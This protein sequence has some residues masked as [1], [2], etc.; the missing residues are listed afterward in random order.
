[1]KTAQ[2][3]TLLAQQTPPVD[4]QAFVR[5]LTWPLAIGGLLAVLVSVVVI[6]VLPAQ[7]FAQPVIWVKF[8]YGVALSLSLAMLLAR[9][10]RPGTPRADAVKWPLAVVLVL[11]G[12]GLVHLMITPPALWAS[13]IFS[14]T[15]FI[16]PWMVLLLSLPTLVGLLLAARALAPTDLRAAGFTAG[17]LAGAI[18]ALA[19]SLV[20]PELSLTFVALWYS[21]GIVLVGLVGWLCAPV[22]LRW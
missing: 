2:L 20:C 14:Q 11:F 12:L 19:Y 17:L 4:R 15:W 7:Q 13:A 22:V 9:L 8:A 3:I 1:M 6:G 10:C 21:A 18:G 5:A 16:C